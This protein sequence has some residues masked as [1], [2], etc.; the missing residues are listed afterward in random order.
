MQVYKHLLKFIA[1][2]VVAAIVCGDD[3]EDEDVYTT[4]DPK[5]REPS[6]CEGKYVCHT[7]TA[8]TMA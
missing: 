5:K 1:I 8:A 3:D 2:F 7:H 6:P 4:K